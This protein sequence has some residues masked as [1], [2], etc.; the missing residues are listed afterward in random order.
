MEDN[1]FTFWN[2]NDIN[3]MTMLQNGT[4]NQKIKSLANDADFRALI[5]NGDDGF[6]V[7]YAYEKGEGD[8]LN[9]R[10]DN[11]VT[12]ME[13]AGIAVMF[14]DGASVKLAD[15]MSQKVAKKL[16]SDELIE[17]A[18]AESKNGLSQIGRA[19][20]KHSDRPG[21]FKGLFNRST[22]MGVNISRQG[23]FNGFREL[24]KQTH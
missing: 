3:R 6:N 19:L 21:V 1:D 12:A 16:I 8:S 13:I 10:I 9:K 4:I 14:V 5:K 18:L 2:P 17:S 15:L 23:G 20:Q 24:P 7:L 22:G 11:I